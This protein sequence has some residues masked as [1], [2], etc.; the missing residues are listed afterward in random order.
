MPSKY[1]SK[2]LHLN[3]NFH[4]SV[5][6]YLDLWDSKKADSFIKTDAN[7]KVLDC[8]KMS[9][10]PNSGIHANILV[11]PYGKGKSHLV[12]K[13]LHDN[14][15]YFK[16]VINGNSTDL[17]MQFRNALEI[18][19]TEQKELVD[20]SAKD[21]KKFED[22]ID[23][24][25]IE[26]Y[27]VVSKVVAE[28]NNKQNLKGIIIVFDEFSKY[29]EQADSV[30]TKFLQD[31]AETCNRVGNLN[32]LLITH[33]SFANYGDNLELAKVEGR[34]NE[35]S[36]HNNFNNS[37][38][39]I[40]AAFQLNLPKN[41]G[42]NFPKE[43]PDGSFMKIFGTSDDDGLFEGVYP[44]HPVTLFLLPRVSEFVAQNERTMFTFVS[45]TQK[46]SLYDFC[47]NHQVGEFLTPDYLFDYFEDQFRKLD[48]GSD[49]FGFYDRA[50]K[51][52]SSFEEGDLRASIVKTLALIYIAGYFEQLPPTLNILETIYFDNLDDFTKALTQL[53]SDNCVI[54]EMHS[55]G[56]LTL[57]QAS[58]VNLLEAIEQET[59]ILQSRFSGQS[60]LNKL[61]KFKYVLPIRHND[62]KCVL[63]YFHLR[64]DDSLNEEFD[65]SPLDYDAQ[66]NS[67]ADGELVVKYDHS[68]DDELR[69][70]QAIDSLLNK[71]VEGSIYANELKFIR[72]DYFVKVNDYISQAVDEN[73][74]HNFSELLSRKCDE[75]YKNHF[76]LNYEMINRA[77]I[78][79]ISLKARAK[80]LNVL[81]N[82]KHR[83]NSAIN[84][85]QVIKYAP[86]EWSMQEKMIF[87]VF[88][89]A[90]K[91]DASKNETPSFQRVE[92]LICDY[93][94]DVG[95]SKVGSS[96]KSFGEI[97]ANLMGVKHG[98][99]IKKGVVALL[100]SE[101]FGNVIS[102]G[103]S[104][105]IYNQRDEEVHLKGELFAVIDSDPQKWSY[106]F[107]EHLVLRDNLKKLSG[108]FADFVVRDSSL[109]D[110]EEGSEAGDLPTP[111]QMAE[112]LNRWFYSLPNLTV[113]S[114]MIGDKW[115][116]GYDILGSIKQTIVHP[117]QFFESM[118]TDE[119]A[120]LIQI[121]SRLDIYLNKVYSQFAEQLNITVTEV[122]SFIRARTGLKLRDISQD[123][124]NRLIAE[125]SGGFDS[126]GSET[127]KSINTKKE[128]RRFEGRA[129]LL[130]NEISS[131][132]KEMGSAVS[133][134]EKMDVLKEMLEGV[135]HGLL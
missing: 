121:K 16:V 122:D 26:A 69:K 120:N 75:L 52:I 6:L 44:L 15:D 77:Q 107:V 127:I 92:K 71:A 31:F 41:K 102:S 81:L 90:L 111:H 34:F 113:T 46:N 129:R 123:V 8:L 116:E 64:F 14:S 53:Q 25:V 98:I 48:F 134:S 11:G 58:G 106:K 33:K 10:Y 109:T 95:S 67:K 132:L 118:N 4:T 135:K 133:Q 57:R 91:S 76:V 40:K 73:K 104:V 42:F 74:A 30:N 80:V 101:V 78:T 22:I 43:E 65:I 55:S 18:S 38:Q 54:Y 108:V 51:I 3:E 12:L 47:N 87:W 32:L 27:K 100:I 83:L 82:K 45:S 28:T 63:R 117:S 114:C 79:G 130:S 9:L 128:L 21:L 94:G 131:A 105:I 1:L 19:L 93:N 103:K 70:I 36:L 49:A 88:K 125:E 37:Y 39:L 62:E 72:D 59:Q 13:F 61:V 2:Y 60:V 68:I 119:V 99:G 86:D 35:I 5:N 66:L 20:F 126:E 112:A 124:F 7:Q 50:S 24:D 85:D 84:S 96:K 29:L 23:K 97:Y 89:C 110:C 115:K 56:Y 17:E